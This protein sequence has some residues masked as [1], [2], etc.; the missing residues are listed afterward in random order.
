MSHDS[1]PH[2]GTSDR[3]AQPSCPHSG[4]AGE[5]S[6]K[7]N[8]GVRM[9]RQEVLFGML[10]SGA[11]MSV[12]SRPVAAAAKLAPPRLPRARAIT[13]WD[14]SWLE[15]RWDGAGY[16]DWDRALDELL[17][18]GYDAVRIDAYP[19]LIAQGPN[20][21]WTV[22]PEWNTQD[23]GSP[24]LNTV[25]V[26][27][28]LTEFMTKCQ[29]RDIKVA[30]ST[31]WREDLANTRMLIDGPQK[32]AAFW[33]AALDAINQAGLMDAVMLV[34][35]SNEWPGLQWTPFVQPPIGWG[36]WDDPRSLKYMR[37][38]IGV[39]REKYPELPMHFSSNAV[40]RIERYGNVDLSFTDLID[41]HLWMAVENGNEFYNRVGYNYE[42]YS[43]IG[44]EKVVAN[45][46]R[47]Y[48]ERPLHW[49]SLLKKKIDAV[50]AAARK[51]RLPLITTECWGIVD[52]KDGP[53]LPWDWVKEICAVG[54][55]HAASTGQWAAMATSNFCGPQF[56]GMW[57]D[58][59]WHQR[60]TTAIKKAPLHPSVAGSRLMARL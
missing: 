8:G 11:A 43:P 25:R 56:V 17:E 46:A 23:W 47:T 10:A 9:T 30:L 59:S 13:M 3:N 45:A 32:M 18:R 29:Q 57:R 55:L 20:A 19:H 35:F 53:L 16:E 34:D 28:A 4:A 33:L 26:L 54:T 39:V 51:G 6:A 31:W 37:E 42:R 36:N 15:R 5:R 1:K 21:D 40:D 48:R 14:F 24:A 22:K 49:Q 44:Y 38:V 7:G 12:G 50:A 27:P 2:S 58:V 52:Y 41:H 60:L